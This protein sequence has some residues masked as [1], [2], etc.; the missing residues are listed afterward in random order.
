M[1]RWQAAVLAA[2][3]AWFHLRHGRHPGFR[4]TE[5]DD[6]LGVVCFADGHGLG[7]IADGTG[8]VTA[9]GKPF[10]MASTAAAAGNARDRRRP[11]PAGDGPRLARK[12]RSHHPRGTPVPSFE[13]EL[14]AAAAA[15]PLDEALAGLKRIA[16]AAG[17]F[18]QTWQAWLDR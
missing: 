17:I 11:R 6:L 5:A 10:L 4:V 13:D 2:R 9:E 8:W 3:I 12:P 15:A 16:E 1:N 7:V 14:R 18:E